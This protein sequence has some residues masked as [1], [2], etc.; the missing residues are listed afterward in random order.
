MWPTVGPFICRNEADASCKSLLD[1]VCPF[2]EVVGLGEKVVLRVASVL[3][4]GHVCHTWVGLEVV[5][6]ESQV[7]FLETLLQW[8]QS[9]G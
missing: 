6:C 5:L 4:A 7:E 1:P 2:F 9:F 3:G 8:L